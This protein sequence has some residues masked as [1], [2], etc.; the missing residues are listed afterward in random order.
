M[1]RCFCAV[2]IHRGYKTDHL[3]SQINQILTTIVLKTAELLTGIDCSNLY[4]VNL[5][6]SQMLRHEIE[7]KAFAL[8][9]VRTAAQKTQTQVTLN[10]SSC[11]PSLQSGF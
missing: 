4:T 9:K 8:A 3:K 2:P 6:V 7:F 1:S 11:P 10:V 5:V